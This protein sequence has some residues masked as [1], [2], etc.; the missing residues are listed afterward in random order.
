MPDI[1]NT[2]VVNLFGGPGTGKSTTAAGVFSL[3]KQRGVLA[4]LIQEY[5]KDK[6]WELSPNTLRNQIYIFGKQHHRLWRVV[7]QVDVLVTDSPLLL[8][9]YYGHSLGANFAALVNQEHG[10]SR[11]LNIFLNRVKPFEQAG[12]LQNEKE[13][14]EIDRAIIT[15]LKGRPYVQRDAD[16]YAPTAIADIICNML[17]VQWPK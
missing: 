17:G 12:R 8:S 7:G 9:L 14:T 1:R 16:V 13:A 10:K 2:L 3:L 4:E 6:V 15:I 11:N 5:A